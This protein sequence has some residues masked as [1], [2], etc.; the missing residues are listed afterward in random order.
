MTALS[1]QGKT[2]NTWLTCTPVPKP[3][4][5]NSRERAKKGRPQVRKRTG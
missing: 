1:M 3:I 2:D 5:P 4:C